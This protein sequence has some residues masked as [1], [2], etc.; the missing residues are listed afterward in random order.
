[1]R[2]HN[3]AQAEPREGFSFVPAQN[4]SIGTAESSKAQCKTTSFVEGVCELE[5]KRTP[6]KRMLCEK[7]IHEPFLAFRQSPS[8]NGY[9]D[10]DAM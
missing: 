6:D 10:D 2:T 1:M 9:T 4:V 5:S 8:Y 3:I 7:D